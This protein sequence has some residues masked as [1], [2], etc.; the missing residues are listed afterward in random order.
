MVFVNLQIFSNSQIHLQKCIK[1]IKQVPRFAKITFKFRP[2]FSLWSKKKAKKVF[3]VLKSPHVNK[4]AQEQFGYV[5]SYALI[6]MKNCQIF[7]LLILIKE[8]QKITNY[9]AHIKFKLFIPDENSVTFTKS[10][11]YKLLFYFSSK[12]AKKYLKLLNKHGQL[13]FYA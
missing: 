7:K 9:D 1:I 2:F 6:N 4:S 13:K 5:F 11:F 3:T 8:L 12:S 10:R